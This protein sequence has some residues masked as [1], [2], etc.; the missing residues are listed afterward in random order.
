MIFALGLGQ[1]F[2]NYHGNG[3]IR[4]VST[5]AAQFTL[6]FLFAVAGYLTKMTTIIT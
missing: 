2:I 6:L 1:I 5:N 4:R 3:Q